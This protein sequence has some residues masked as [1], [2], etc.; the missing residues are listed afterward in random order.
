MTASFLATVPVL[1][2]FEQKDLE[3]LARVMRPREAPPGEVLWRVGDE[4]TAMLLVVGGLVSVALPLPGERDVELTRL[5]PK[6]M[7]G[8][9]PL[10]DGGRHSATARVIEH[11][12]LLSLSRAD[13]AALAYRGHP[14]AL[15]LKRRIARVACSRLRL[16]FAALA[17][18]IDAGEGSAEPLQVSED[19]E[20]C[21]P[22]DSGYVR[23]LGTFHAFDEMALSGFLTAGRFARCP[24]RSTLLVEGRPSKACYLTLNGAVEKVLIRGGRRIRVGLAGPGH[25]FGYEGLIDGGPAPVTAI[26]RE[27]ALLLMLPQEPFERLF[28]GHTSGSHAFLDVVLRDLFAA[29][30]YAHRPHARLAASI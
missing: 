24:A 13:F 26:A 9:I 11:A 28:E 12:Q 6:E 2:G 23:R 19:L 17:D 10:L 5:G 1:D 15:A 18:T 3:E 30:R 4:A 27:R 22:P 16:H 29:L 21:D 25:A 7:L 20:P 14:T 8:E